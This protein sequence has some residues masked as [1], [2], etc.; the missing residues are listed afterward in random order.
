M[1]PQSSSVVLGRPTGLAA[2]GALDAALF[3]IWGNGRH[4]GDRI[5]ADLEDRF[6][7][8]GLSEV[9]WSTAR[10]MENFRRFYSDLPVRGVYH[11]HAK[12]RGPFLAALVVDPRPDIAQRSTSRGPRVVNGH[13]LDA[14]TQYRGWAGELTIHCTETPFETER[15]LTMLFGLGPRRFET[16]PARGEIPKIQ[17]DLT[18]AAGWSSERELFEILNRSVRYVLTGGPGLGPD[19]GALDSPYVQLLTDDYLTLHAVLNG[20]PSL[21]WPHGGAF[22]VRVADRSIEVRVRFVGDGFYDVSWARHL[23]DARFLDESG[24]YRVPSEE[25]F[26]T[27]VYGL[28]SRR[29]PAGA[30]DPGWLGGLARDLEVDEWPPDATV[31]SDRVAPLV[32]R[33]LT[34]RG[35]QAPEPLDPSV[36]SSGPLSRWLHRARHAARCQAS[37]ARDRTLFHFPG[38]RRMKSF[39]PGRAVGAAR[40][41][42]GHPRFFF[43]RRAVLLGRGLLFLGRRYRCPLCGWSL[44]GFVGEW[45]LL[46]SNHDGYCPRCNS[47]ARHRRLWLYLQEHTELPTADLELLE[48]APWWALSR[49][50]RRAPNVSFTGLDIER[51]GPH[52][53]VVGD[54]ADMPLESDFF[55]AVLCIHTLEHVGDDRTAMRELHRVTKPGGWAVVSVPLRLDGTT[56]EDPSIT[57]PED[58][59]RAFGERSHVR[60]YG[61]DLADR[62]RD[63]GFTVGV[64][65]AD[66]IPL[67]TR[68][69]FGLRDDENLFLCRKGARAT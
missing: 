65:W 69:R 53:T 54:A 38:I 28:Q 37:L 47:K 5:L 35:A 16:E 58:R 41:P 32:D 22:Q 21:P 17:R 26:R 52:V 59:L 24:R 60:L 66:R 20:R 33:W 46:S 48:I 50:L 8:L 31:P 63:A 67:E 45:G 42:L 30:A 1:T 9:S 39:G 25:D 6:E 61:P 40:A 27:L 68:Q 62:L 15:D 23:L 19:D 34:E 13:F 64:D 51:R 36:S 55:D 4:A 2:A 7:V 57:D 12:G 56:Y 11:T 10:V 3:V 18:G 43:V 44:R 14:K 49:R 29:V